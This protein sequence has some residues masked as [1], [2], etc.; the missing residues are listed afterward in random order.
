MAR[1]N[2]EGRGVD[3]H[4]DLWTVSYQPDWLRW[5]K[6]SRELPDGRR[7]STMTLFRNPARRAEDRP[8]KVIRTRVAAADGSAEFLVALEDREGLVDQI[9]VHVRKPRGRRAELVKF[10]I[11]GGMPTP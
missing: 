6:V 11:K 8:G 7:R 5:V 1:H 10:V 4:G 9:V 2:R 3:Q